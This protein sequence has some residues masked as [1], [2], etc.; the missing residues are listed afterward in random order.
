MVTFCV[1]VLLYRDNEVLLVEHTE[2]ARLPKGSH[3]FPAGRV[4]KGESPEQAAI[5]ELKEETGLETSL[6]YLHKL[7]IDPSA[8]R[9]KM[10]EGFEDFNFQ[11]FLCTSYSGILTP[12]LETIPHFIRL[13]SLE[14]LLLVDNDVIELS[15]KWY[16]L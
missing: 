6:Q 11:P 9:L 8:S 7:P 4:E 10:K 1:G 13:D 16:N 3:G 14:N 15:R 2:H 12:S 5:R